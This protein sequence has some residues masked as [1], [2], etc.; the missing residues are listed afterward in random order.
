M[1]LNMHTSI[2]CTREEVAQRVHEG[3]SWEIQNVF[4]LQVW[5]GGQEQI[6]WDNA[7]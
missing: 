1:Q 5:V 4:Y 7:K 2:I 3:G 6:L